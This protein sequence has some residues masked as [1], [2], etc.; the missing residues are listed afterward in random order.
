MLVNQLFTKKKGK[1]EKRGGQEGEGKK[2]QERG[3]GEEG[4]R[5]RKEK[6]SLIWI[7]GIC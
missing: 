5:R 4:R 1:K 7:C 3:K 2:G 6:K